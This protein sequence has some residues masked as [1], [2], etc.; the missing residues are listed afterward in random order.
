MSNNTLTQENFDKLGA[1]IQ[2]MKDV[3]GALM[4]VMQK[5]QEI[6]GYIG[7][8]IQEYIADKMGVMLSE[9]YG[10][11]TFYSQFALEPKGEHVIS[12]CLGTA[13]YVRGAQKVLDKLAEVLEVEPGRT[14]PDGLFTLQ[15]T[16]CL[17]CCGLAPVIT[18]GEDVYG[19][20]TPDAIPGIIEKYRA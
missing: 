2:E 4:P 10:V 8:P 17:G 18:I 12:V 5:A 19:R 11:S 3:K 15:P 13:C 7:E 16:R 14:T 20:L 9:V 6:F 1:Y